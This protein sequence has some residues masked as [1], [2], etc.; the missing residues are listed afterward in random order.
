[1]VQQRGKKW[2]ANARLADGTRVRPYFATKTEALAWEANA[3]L[4]LEKGNDPPRTSKMLSRSTEPD[5]GHTRDFSTLGSIFDHVEKTEWARMKSA[6]T[7]I[8][9]GKQ[10]CDYFGRAHPIAEITAPDI[11][12]MKLWFSSVGMAPA[13]VNRRIAALSK[14]LKCAR[15]VGALAVQPV[16][17]WNREEQSRF[18]Y[19]DRVEEAQ[20][21]DYLTARGDNDLYDLVVLLTDTGARCWSEMCPVK[22]DAFGPGFASVTFWT[23]KTGRPRTVPVTQRSRALLKAR[24]A[25]A[26]KA[27]G[28]FSSLNRWTLI[29]R[30][31]R[32]RRELGMNDVTP[33]TLRHTCCT[34]LVLGGVDVKRVMQWMGHSAIV[35][36]MRYMQ[37]KPTALEDVLHVIEA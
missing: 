30:W 20:I 17:K 26:G 35:T 11:A 28:P 19:I 9:N 7:L 8:R 25:D 34:R 1:M 2:Q 12:E 6:E 36:T 23:T 3:R 14:M 13:T 22:W 32:M 27:S 24:R 4:A 15:E 18:R 37:I 16:V 33:H 10:V 21:L 29:D 31:K 5:R